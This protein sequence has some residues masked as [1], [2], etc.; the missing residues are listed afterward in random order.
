MKLK[1]HIKQS[2]LIAVMPIIFSGSLTAQTEGRHVKVFAS[3]AKE[4]E[5]L[6]AQPD[7]VL[8]Q[9]LETENLLIN[10]YPEFRYQ[11]IL[12]FGAAFTETSAYNFSLLSPDAQQ[13]VTEYLFGKTGIGMNFCRTHINSSD[14]GL[15]E[16][17]YVENGDVELKTFNIDR[18]RKY[19]L[20]MV[21]AALRVNPD[22]WL[23]ASPW[24]PPAWMKDNNSVIRGGH[25][26]P[27]FYQTWA[28]YFSL[29]LKE[30]Q[31]EGVNFFGVTIQNEAKAVQT[32]ESCIWSGREEG[33][34]AV[35]F[36]RPALDKNGF[37]EA[38]I[39]IWDHNK[40]RVMERA[41]ESMSVP[42]ADKAIWGIAHHWYSGDHFDNLR[43]A[44]ELFPDK[45]LIATE[46]SG[47]GVRSREIDWQ[48]VERYA[49]ETIGDFNNFTSAIVAWNMIVELETG[50]PYHN[51]S[52]GTSAPIFYDPKT[53]E[54]ILGTL[55]YTKG[56][57]SKFIR[58]GAVRIG[59]STYSDAV[60]AAA[61]SNPDGE[62][63]VVILN[64]S[65]EDA[66]P[67]IR[68]NNSTVTF[69]L[70]AKSLLTMVIPQ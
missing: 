33:E 70:P 21:K 29:Y 68:L 46:N 30:F 53:K 45:P 34:F 32:W 27:N 43:M 39:M 17:T 69:N 35:N 50:G 1:N 37:G 3:S 64:T 49:R 20:P 55:Y 62:I 4:K 18:E 25:L 51:R 8:Q 63:I 67:K 16:Y 65:E 61:F 48:A 9:D 41:R 60:K 24:S 19:V 6:V 10:V 52:T 47:G 66:T 5:M 14:F 42:G 12:G 22:L 40:E 56:H 44:H 54:F 57:F 59:S 38:K 13:K 58:R 28:D 7:I 15:D 2:V 36:L 26:L 23:F 31:K 11:Q